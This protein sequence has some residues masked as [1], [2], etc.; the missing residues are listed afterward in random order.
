MSTNKTRI[1]C[2]LDDK[3]KDKYIQFKNDR[4]IGDSE[5]I[6]KIL[7]EYFAVSLENK[8]A[9]NYEQQ[10]SLLEES[11]ELE[12]SPIKR[13]LDYLEMILEKLIGKLSSELPVESPTSLPVESPSKLPVE[14]SSKTLTK[15]D[16]AKIVGVDPKTVARWIKAEKFELF[17]KEYFWNSE[18][19]CFELV[20]S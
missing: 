3:V 12:L 18:K 2:Y 14:L 5:T 11:L 1:Q 6:N 20:S 9:I 4:G 8:E 10:K 13:R 17:P 16:M 19:A 7:I 15:K